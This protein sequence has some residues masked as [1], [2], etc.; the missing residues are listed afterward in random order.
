MSYLMFCKLEVF[1]VLL[2]HQQYL[3]K[4]RK[5]TVPQKIDRTNKKKSPVVLIPSHQSEA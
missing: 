2:K 4:I 5:K 1:N 3:E